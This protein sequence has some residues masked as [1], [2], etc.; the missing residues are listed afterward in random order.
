M[1]AEEFTTPLQTKVNGTQYL[2]EAFQSPHLDFFLML[3]SLVS[4]LGNSAQANYAAGNAY[5]DAVATTPNPSSN[6]HFMSLNLGAMADVGVVA[7]NPKLGDYLVRQGYNL[8]RLTEL[9]RI[10]EYAMSPQA[11]IDNC[12][13][14]ILGFNRTSM[15]ESENHFMLEN[16][17]LSHIPHPKTKESSSSS[18]GNHQLEGTT[19]RQPSL[20]ERIANAKDEDELKGI[21]AQAIAAKIAALLCLEPDALDS[22]APVREL[23]LDSLVLIEV[24]HWIA[25]KF[26]RVLQIIQISEAESLG[27]LAAVVVGK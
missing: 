17:M 7:A 5:L 19:K 4:V 21:V 18:N 12:H 20:E 11:K 1:T 10:L 16:P 23:G 22:D 27:A 26:K 8:V 13:Q 14:I 24:R 3:S 15:S 25:N 9:L 6:T 2:I